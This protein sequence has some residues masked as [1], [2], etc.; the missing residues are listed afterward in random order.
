MSVEVVGSLVGSAS[1]HVISFLSTL[2]VTPIL[3]VGVGTMS[4][5]RCI[6]DGVVP[7]RIFIT[8]ANTEETLPGYT[9]T[10]AYIK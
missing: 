9:W 8:F 10:Y 5:V 1:F 4:C 3:A 7:V 6:L 2:V